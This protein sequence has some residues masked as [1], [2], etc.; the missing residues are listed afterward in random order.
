M[1]TYCDNLFMAVIVNFAVAVAASYSHT[2]ARIADDPVSKNNN[3]S[4]KRVH[5]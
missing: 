3:L 1:E 5:V 4:D 2:R